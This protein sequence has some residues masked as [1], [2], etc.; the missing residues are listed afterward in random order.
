MLNARNIMRSPAVPSAVLLYGIIFLFAGTY[1]SKV[2]WQ[3]AYTVALYLSV[4]VWSAT[5]VF[6]RFGRHR[7]SFNRIDL[8]FSI[9]LLAI[10]LSSAINWWDGTA[11]Y[12]KMMP[13]FILVPYALGRVMLGKDGYLLRNILIGMGILLLPLIFT[14]YLRVLQ[15]G[16]PYSNSPNPTLFGLGHGVMLSGVLLSATFLSLTSALLSPDDTRS[17]LGMSSPS[18]RLISYVTLAVIIVTMGWIAPRGS[19]VAAIPAVA[20]LF[21][22]SPKSASKQKRQ[23]LLVIALALAIATAHTL[24]RKE[25]TE[26]YSAILNP[27]VLDENTTGKAL[28]S[29]TGTKQMMSILGNEACETIVDSVSDRWVHYRQA[30]ALFLSKPIFGAGANQY[31]AYA[32]TGPGSFP[33]ST[34]LQVFAELGASVGLVYCILVWKTFRV[35]LRSR[36]RIS[37]LA[38]ESLWAWFAS[39]FLMQFLFA[40]LSGNYFLS[41]GMYYFFGIAANALDQD[42]GAVRGSRPCTSW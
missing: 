35:L 17:P 27:P 20:S 8:L 16:L 9:F 3:R 25:S 15:Y 38:A 7:S 40:Q 36:E 12:F 23:I 2:P 28:V 31:G 26:F 34:V 24:L 14:E 33:H 32:C 19:V 30:L 11:E 21:M 42:A 5:V 18:G 6:Q 1:F 22:L 10:L 29:S 37:E 4:S 41:A 39:F 13:V